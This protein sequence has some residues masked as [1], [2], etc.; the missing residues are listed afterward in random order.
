MKR[1]IES[2]TLMF[3]SAMGASPMVSNKN[4]STRRGTIR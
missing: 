3:G 4:R 1:L 2:L